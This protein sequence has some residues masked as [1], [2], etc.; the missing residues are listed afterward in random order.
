MSILSGI[1]Q[2]PAVF[3]GGT[4]TSLEGGTSGSIP[5]QSAPD[6]TA[7]LANGSAGQYLTSQGTTLPPIWS[8]PNPNPTTAQIPVLVSSVENIINF[9]TVIGQQIVN[10]NLN[11]NYDITGFQQGYYQYTI[12]INFT[13]TVPTGI[14]VD[15]INSVNFDFS[16]NQPS[17]AVL[18]NCACGAITNYEVVGSGSL[19]PTVNSITLTGLVLV[20]SQ[21]K[22][23][24]N[25]VFVPITITTTSTQ[26]INFSIQL[27]LTYLYY[28]PLN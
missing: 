20:P 1:G 8:T 4:A 26:Q 14:T 6:T 27:F 21:T 17:S 15:S 28:L 3:G 10:I 13:G 18:Y 5:Y 16:T 12:V 2:S 24:L 25:A 9:P 11:N 7:F 22:T 19:D 23:I